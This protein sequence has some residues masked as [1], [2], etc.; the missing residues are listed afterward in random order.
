MTPNYLRIYQQVLGSKS[1]ILSEKTRLV[2]IQETINALF[3][4]NPSL[5]E[6]HM[7][8]YPLV[9]DCT[10][11]PFADY[12]DFLRDLLSPSG[13]LG[14]AQ[15]LGKIGND[16]IQKSIDNDQNIDDLIDLL[17][18]TVSFFDPIENQDLV[19]KYYWLPLVVAARPSNSGNIN[20]DLIQ[21][22]SPNM[23]IVAFDVL[24]GNIGIRSFRTST[25]TY[26]NNPES[27][28]RFKLVANII[29]LDTSHFK[30]NQL[31]AMVDDCKNQLQDFTNQQLDKMEDA[32]LF[33]KNLDMFDFGNYAKPYEQN[34]RQYAQ[35]VPIVYDDEDSG[36][37]GNSSR[38]K[39]TLE[40]RK[41]Y[42]SRAKA[43]ISNQI[44]S[45]AIPIGL[46]A[47]SIYSVYYFAKK[48]T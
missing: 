45:K 33:L 30:T 24:L 36:N 6:E 27:I 46:A 22:I 25:P 47:T 21:Y 12:L 37:S 44:A 34:Y 40:T 20:S 26:F 28:H 18:Q 8:D 2:A 35:I 31:S 4:N 41:N 29:G 5:R 14:S 16:L 11:G 7:L 15:M 38:Q 19:I 39:G 3:K 32:I 42:P 9:K 17:K 10:H 43:S 13:D 1:K 48:T 23:K